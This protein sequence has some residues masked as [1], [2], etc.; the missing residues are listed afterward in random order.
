MEISNKVHEAIDG[1]KLPGEL[2][3]CIRYGSGH[4][5]DT[6]RLT[7]E[8]P[9]GTK[10][11][12]LQRMSKSI[13][14]KPVE[15]MENVSGVT[16]WL[17]KKIIE[18][19][20]DPERETLTL[21]KSND[22]LPY[23][24][25]STGEYWRVYLFIEGATCYDAVKDDNDF[26][27]SA[28]AFGHFQRLLADYPAETLHETIKD[29]H[30]TPD[31]L[32]KFKKAVAEDIFGRA[33]S[34]QKEIDFILEREELT[35]ALYDLQLDGRLPLRVTHNDTKLNNIMIDDETGKAICVIDLDTVMPGLTANDFGD[36]IRFGASTALE[37]EQDLSKVSCD[38][39]LFDVY[40][41]GFIEGCGGALTDLEIDM[42]PM[43]AILMTFENGIRFLTDHLEGDHYFHIHREGHNLDRCR[44]QL[45]LVKDMQEKLPQMNAII[46]K[47][48]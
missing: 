30:N 11:Y 40:A 6:Y 3:E 20:G 25:D 39:H 46:Q 7:Y 43:G 48:K 10:R 27:Q 22:G 34:V 2:K 4:I 24:V 15:L 21:V 23:F 1:F 9:Q 8:T 32:E 41:R 35:H 37:D 36:S 31:R 38:L 18:N 26:Y 5:N 47:Y 45:T 12:I 42:L 33:A 44:T 19:G 14:K 29:F 16:A 17:R 28:V 13:F